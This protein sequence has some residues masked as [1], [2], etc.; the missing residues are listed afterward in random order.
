MSCWEMNPDL[1]D[2]EPKVCWMLRRTTMSM[3]RLS[4]NPTRRA[5]RVS[6]LPSHLLLYNKA[7]LSFSYSGFGLTPVLPALVVDDSPTAQSPPNHGIQPLV[8]ETQR[9]VIETQSPAIETPRPINPTIASF[10]SLVE[11]SSSASPFLRDE[12]TPSSRTEVISDVVSATGSP[13]DERKRYYCEPCEKE[14]QTA[15]GYYLHMRHAKTHQTFGYQCCCKYWTHR[16]DT[17]RRHINRVFK[18]NGLEPFVCLCGYQVNSTRPGSMD[19]IWEH[20]EAC[21]HETLERRRRYP[22]S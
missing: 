19:L 7:P 11:V 3:A 17:F 8:I 16:K 1:I 18:C 10:L 2:L 5:I 9:P 6:A 15:G 21:R 4:K 20:I 14:F 22:R 12:P 13:R